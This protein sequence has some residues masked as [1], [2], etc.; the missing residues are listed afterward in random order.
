M[1]YISPAGGKLSSA[2]LHQRATM[3][4]TTTSAGHRGLHQYNKSRQPPNLKDMN[5]LQLALGT[6]PSQ[7][8]QP[9]SSMKSASSHAGKA[10]DEAAI[11]ARIADDQEGAVLGLYS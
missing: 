7:T 8:F 4:G 9:R 3:P 6:S 11:S 10:F 5:P 2:Q 1:L